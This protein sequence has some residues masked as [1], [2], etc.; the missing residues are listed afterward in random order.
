LNFLVVLIGI[1]ELSLSESLMMGGSATLVQCLWRAK[2]RPKFG[3]V[4]FNVANAVIAVS[5]A[6]CLYR[7]P[8]LRG[9]KFGEPL[10]LVLVA[11]I[12][13]V[14]NT[15]PAA[16]VIS[17]TE[18]KLFRNIWN[19]CYF[20]TFPYYMIGAGIAEIVHIGNQHF[21]WQAL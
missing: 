16:V 13:F 6:A 18:G 19:D 11:G 17:L 7:A 4:L 12:Y 14:A 21:G 15:F 1:V 9:S 2:E 5:L 8:F 3:Q 10:A 20:W